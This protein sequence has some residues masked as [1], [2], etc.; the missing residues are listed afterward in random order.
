M[1]ENSVQPVQG[2]DCAKCWK[3]DICQQAELGTGKFCINYQ[4]KRP[5]PKG[6]DPNEAWNRGDSDVFY[7]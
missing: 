4:V 5:T 2:P 1:D 7:M 3:K 6:P